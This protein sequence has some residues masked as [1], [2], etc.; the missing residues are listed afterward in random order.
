MAASSQTVASVSENSEILDD[1]IEKSSSELKKQEDPVLF[2]F[3]CRVDQADDY[4]Y[5]PGRGWGSKQI[6]VTDF[7]ILMFD[8]NDKTGLNGNPWK[9]LGVSFTD[10]LYSNLD[11]ETLEF[12]GMRRKKLLGAPGAVAI[13]SFDRFGNWTD[14]NKTLDDVGQT[15]NLEKLEISGDPKHMNALIELRKNDDFINLIRR[16]HLERRRSQIFP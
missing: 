14:V 5:T 1:E 12:C 15:L 3:T 9:Y 4:D 6:T 13:G 11:P 2:W 10:F 8:D 16:K 7:M